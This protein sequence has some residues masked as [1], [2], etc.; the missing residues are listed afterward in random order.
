L[1]ES[2]I[3]PTAAQE[4][5]C[6]HCHRVYETAEELRRHVEVL[7][8]DKEQHFNDDAGLGTKPRIPSKKMRR[9]RNRLGIVANL[10]SLAMSGALKTHLMYRSNMSF[11]ML[12][13]YLDHLE[14]NGLIEE[15]Y[16]AERR[17]IFY[18]TT[19]RGIQFLESYRTL[20]DLAPPFVGETTAF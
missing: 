17:K 12:R 10:L 9:N 11:A 20:G 6:P 14:R 5:A 4:L 3:S 7:G 13:D 19:D 2:P 16:D 18:K 8:L 1:T 15:G